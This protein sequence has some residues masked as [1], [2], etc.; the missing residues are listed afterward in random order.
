LRTQL[1]AKIQSAFFWKISSI[2]IS[3]SMSYHDYSS[4]SHSIRRFCPGP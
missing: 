4:K 3:G 1:K 2:T